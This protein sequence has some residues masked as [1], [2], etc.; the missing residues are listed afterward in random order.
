MITIRTLTTRTSSTTMLLVGICLRKG[1][2]ILVISNKLLHNMAIRSSSLGKRNTL[3]TKHQLK[4][5][6]ITILKQNTKGTMPS[7]ASILLQ[8]LGNTK[9][10]LKSSTLLDTQHPLRANF[11]AVGKG[12]LL[13]GTTSRTTKGTTLLLRIE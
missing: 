8:L 10:E 11:Q 3:D 5:K 13:R 6:V 1:L 12:S 9:P 7:T 2:I 4:D